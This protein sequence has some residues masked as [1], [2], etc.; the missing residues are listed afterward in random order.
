MIYLMSEH[1]NAFISYRHA[2]RD[3][4][5]AETIQNDLEHFP[6]PAKQKKKSGIRQ[7][8]AGEVKKR[9]KQSASLCPVREEAS[10]AD[11]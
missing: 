9:T 11:L 6:I 10:F 2:P 4:K 8:E 3:M 1:Y 7:A 5:V